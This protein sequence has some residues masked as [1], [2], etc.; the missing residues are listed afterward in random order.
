M[1]YR[2]KR[3]WVE[4]NPHLMCV[5]FSWPLKDKFDNIIPGKERPCPS[6]SP[7]LAPTSVPT[8]A[9]TYDFCRASDPSL[10]L[11]NVYRD[12]RYAATTEEQFARLW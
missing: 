3:L 5:P 2:S 11:T 6:Q 4:D 9:P 12:G 8:L 10:G 1:D 7:T